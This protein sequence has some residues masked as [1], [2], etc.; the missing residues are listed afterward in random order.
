MSPSGK[1]ARR[2]EPAS[3]RA[4]FANARAPKP[5]LTPET[6]ARLTPRQQEVLDQLEDLVEE[7][8]LAKLTMGKIAAHMGCSL[9]TLYGISPSKDELVLAAVDR[10]LR[11]IGREAIGSL[12]PDMPP[13]EMLRAY[14][15]A[16]NVAIEPTR[17]MFARELG[18]IPAS[19]RLV[20]AHEDYLMAVTKS[21]L[22]RAVEEGDIAKV[23]TAAL[24]HVLGGLGRDLA[25]VDARESLDEAPRKTAAQVVD[26]ILKGLTR[27]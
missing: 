25:Q 7:D 2:E 12:D 9:R 3:K 20:D 27:N 5:V 21:L 1:A 8:G 23:D 13:L 17:M 22:D 24:A 26:I 16:A 6:E 19:Q 14:L 10:N 15:D 11:R 18:S 4:R